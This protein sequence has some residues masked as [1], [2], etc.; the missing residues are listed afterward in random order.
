[1]IT[2]H[3]KKINKEKRAVEF[4]MKV[5]P[6]GNNIVLGLLFSVGDFIMTPIHGLQLTPAAYF[7]EGLGAVLGFVLGVSVE[8][9]DN[10]TSAKL[11]HIKTK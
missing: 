1:M 9:N 6:K 4:L 11:P 5:Q 8:D 2:K 3:V 7:V 10:K